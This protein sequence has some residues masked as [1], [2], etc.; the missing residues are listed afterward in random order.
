MSLEFVEWSS[1]IVSGLWSD[2]KEGKLH[3]LP[4]PSSRDFDCVITGK[5]I[6]PTFKL[7]DIKGEETLFFK[8]VT[9]TSALEEIEVSLLSS[10]NLY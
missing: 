8:F 10:T 9:F 4:F 2:R 6:L 5:Q 7:G 1:T 3:P